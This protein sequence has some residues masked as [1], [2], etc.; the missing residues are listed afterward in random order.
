MRG[1][2]ANHSP[3]SLSVVSSHKIKLGEV[4]GLSW[5]AETGGEIIAVGDENFDL[6]VG[7]FKENLQ[8][9]KFNRFSMAKVFSKVDL[10]YIRVFYP[11][12]CGRYRR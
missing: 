5:R 2:D 10:L 6:M 7:S 8:Q 11:S 9:M 4:S 12:R 1:T 3:G